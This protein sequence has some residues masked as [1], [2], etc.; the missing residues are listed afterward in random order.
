MVQTKN[1]DVLVV[2]AGIAGLAAA[3]ALAEAGKD[4]LLLEAR[5]RVGGRA[6]S[7]QAEGSELPVELGAEFVHGQPEELWTL[8]AEAGLRTYELEGRPICFE[9]GVLNE[10]SR[11]D[12]FAVLEDL[13]EDE[14]DST[15][16]EWI[17]AKDIRKET[18]E[19]ATAFVE[20]FNAADARRIGTAALARQQKAED[21]LEGDRGFRIEDGYSALA[22]YLLKKF[23][24]TGGSVRLSTLVTGMAWQKG[25]VRV[26]AMSTSDSQQIE[27][28]GRQCVVTL[29]LGVLQAERVRFDPAPQKVMRAAASLAMGSARR[30]TYI[31]RERFWQEQVPAMGFLFAD[32]GMPRVWWTPS[33]YVA[34][35]ITGWVGG[36]KALDAGQDE[37]FALTG[38]RSLA[39]MFVMGESELRARLVGWHTHDWQHDPLSLGAY[40]YAPKGALDASNAMSEPVEATLFFAGEHTDTTGHWGTVHG[41]LRSGLRSAL[42]ILAS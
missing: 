26:T 41:A 4:V 18:A 40:S 24:G 25:A 12:A 28:A 21:A 31:F 32:E 30:V 35:Q 39:K 33:P 1:Y 27:F 14:P 6:W 16:A 8:I 9:D 5:E 11:G 19:A 10:C 42:Q 37:N 3:R 2:G 20:G 36:P 34:P 29:P 13:S 38:L 17:A 23:E 7:V 15:F 22:E